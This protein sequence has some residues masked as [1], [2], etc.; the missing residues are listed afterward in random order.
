MEQ[1]PLTRDLETLSQTA[2]GIAHGFNNVMT[3][4]IG[5]AEVLMLRHGGNDQ[6]RID[7]LE[8]QKAG[9]R[10]AL[11]SQ[12]LRV[13]SC[14]Q[15]PE[16]TD[17]DLNQTAMTVFHLLRGLVRDDVSITCSV[18][19]APAVAHLDALHLEQA[20]INLALNAEECL[21]RG[22]L[23][24]GVSM[25]PTPG[26]ADSRSASIR[27]SGW[28]TNASESTPS[29]PAGDAGP[30]ASS[31][32]NLGAAYAIVRRNG[33]SLSVDHRPSTVAFTILFPAVA[34][35]RA[36]SVD[37]PEATLVLVIDDESSVRHL[38]SRM[39]RGHGY[40]VL[41][42]AASAA[43]LE[44]FDEHPDGIAVVVADVALGVEDGATLVRDLTASRPALR[45]VLM[46]GYGA[47]SVPEPSSVGAS[48]LLAKPFT[49]SAL[50]DAVQHALTAPRN[51]S[52]KELR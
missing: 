23:H 13:L 46:S 26:S 34:T 21:T 12:Q 29:A 44:L 30:I 37:V 22:R 51:A 52:A 25:E 32:L 3:A 49:A 15:T 18:H 16:A 24:I 9:R 38:A 48:S 14:A 6:D 31:D 19:E 39:L 40:R 36:A 5:Y 43:A 11:L 42:A 10:G 33:G 17:V 41:E 45:A 47:G 1:A 20:L 50:V 7:L 8:I 28:N 27:I 2:T 4:V 35:A